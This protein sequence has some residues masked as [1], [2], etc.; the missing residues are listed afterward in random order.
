[1]KPEIALMKKME[2]LI[3]TF[4]DEM[5]FLKSSPFY[6]ELTKFEEKRQASPTDTETVICLYKEMEILFKT[7]KVSEDFVTEV[8]E[9]DVFDEIEEFLVLMRSLLDLK[10]ND[11]EALK[12]WSLYY[13]AEIASY[14]EALEKFCLFAEE[15]KKTVKRR[16]NNG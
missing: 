3:F 7:W 1:M 10:D 13:E 14:P 15:Y 5:Q 16:D 11:A 9:Q 6:E 2:M 8:E 12:A 4:R